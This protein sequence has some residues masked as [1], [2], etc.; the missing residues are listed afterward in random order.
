MLEFLSYS[1]AQQQIMPGDFILLSLM[2]KTL[3]IMVCYKR[4]AEMFCEPAAVSYTT[5]EMNYSSLAMK[6]DAMFHHY[7]VTPS[8]AVKCSTPMCLKYCKS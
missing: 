3:V 4:T 7:F 6:N 5:D 1:L 2:I 8:C